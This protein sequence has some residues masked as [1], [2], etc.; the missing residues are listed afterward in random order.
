MLQKYMVKNKLNITPLNENE[1]ILVTLIQ[2]IF[3]IIKITNAVFKNI[4][5]EASN[6]MNH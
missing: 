6:S 2:I 3:L 1:L 4:E 5:I